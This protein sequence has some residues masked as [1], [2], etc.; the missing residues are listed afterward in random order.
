MDAPTVVSRLRAEGIACTA[1]RD[2]TLTASLLK[3]REETWVRAI[4]AR[5]S[6]FPGASTFGWG[7]Y[8]TADPR[9]TRA[10]VRFRLGPAPESGVVGSAA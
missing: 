3:P 1:H 4:Q 2:G 5:V 7:E 6:Q 10:V 8:E 9:L